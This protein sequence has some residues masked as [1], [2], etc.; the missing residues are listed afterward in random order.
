MTTYRRRMVPQSRSVVTGV[1]IAAVGILLAA[2]GGTGDAEAPTQSSS[3][4]SQPTSASPSITAPAG[5]GIPEG[6]SPLSGLPGGADQ[7]LLAVKIDNTRAAQPHA[8]LTQADVVYVEEVEWGLTRFIALFATSMPDVVG[9][10]RSA[11]VSDIDI[12]APFGDIP[13]AYSG[14]Q[15]RLL[16]VL[17]KANF[18]DASAL[19]SYTGW[20][21]DPNRRSPTDHMLRPGDVLGVFSDGAVVRD[22]GWV[23]SD[24]PPAGG[25]PVSEVTAQWGSSSVGFR[26]DA[27]AGDYVVQ[28]D[29]ADSR[30]SEGGSQRAAT[31]VI[32]SVRQYDSG[33]GDKFGGV[34]PAIETVGTGSAMVLRDGLM[35]Q[36]TWERDSLEEG[37]RYLMAD[38]SPIPFAIGQEWIVLLDEERTP[39]VR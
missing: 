39:I 34:T 22:I 2:C 17:A 21:D 13:F 6:A 25:T 5:P 16:P 10:V 33:Y 11:R 36:V 37:T 14:A 26:W 18:I 38:G 3:T 23:F 24:E 4:S 9:P 28:I 29:G 19:A 7:P 15:S 12:L 8:G 1:V 35:F 32:Q 27:S 30:A 31:V 20:F